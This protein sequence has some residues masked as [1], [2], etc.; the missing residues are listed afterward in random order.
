MALTPF[1]FVPSDGLRNTSTYPT[2]PDNETDARDQIQT[3]LDEL[4]DGLNSV[5]NELLSGT[6]GQILRVNSGGTALEWVTPSNIGSSTISYSMDGNPAAGSS[7][8]WVIPIGIYAIKG[9]MLIIPTNRTNN[10]GSFIIF[11]KDASVAKCMSNAAG[12]VY[13]YDANIDTYITDQMYS[14]LTDAISIQDVYIDGTDLKIVF[15]N[16]SA[17]AKTLDVRATWEVEI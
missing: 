8:T 9:R 1:A 14:T 13:N 15:K 11:G 7:Y 4:K 2:T 17:S 16:R 6:A 10:K 12:F 5:I 3:P